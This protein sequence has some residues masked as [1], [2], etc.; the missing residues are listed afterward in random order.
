MPTKV[1]IF[2]DRH[3]V[4]TV[5]DEHRPGSR[6]TFVMSGV[7]RPRLGVTAIRAFMPLVPGS[8]GRCGAASHSPRYGDR[9]SCAAVE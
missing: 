8:H 2:D 9:A 4:Q 5:G 1:R 3:T 6:P 7:V